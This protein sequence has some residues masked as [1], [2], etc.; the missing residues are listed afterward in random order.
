MVIREKSDDL[1]GLAFRN[2][3]QLFQSVHGNGL[4]VFQIVNRSGVKT[5]LSDE[6]I[7]G[8]ALF[9]HGFPQ[10]FVADH[11]LLLRA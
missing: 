7:G 3:T 1:I 9:V 6:G 2:E 11:T 4:A 5:V 10:W 8:N